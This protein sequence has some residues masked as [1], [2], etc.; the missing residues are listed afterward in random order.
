VDVVEM[1]GCFDLVSGLLL[2]FVVLDDGV[3]GGG[4]MMNLIVVD[5]DGNVCVLMMSFGFGLGDWV[6]G[7]DL[8]LNS[9]F[10]EIDFVWGVFVLGIWMESMMVLMFVF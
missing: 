1:F 6:L 3:C 8:Y 9:M 5:G 4:Y 2:L 7:F 10:G